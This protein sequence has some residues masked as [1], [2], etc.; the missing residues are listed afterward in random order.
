M[1]AESEV[2]GSE[3]HHSPIREACSKSK[4]VLKQAGRDHLASL[5]SVAITV[6]VMVEECISGAGYMDLT[7][8]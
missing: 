5:Q 8:H 1:G 2:P 6:T 3:S 4:R 7:V